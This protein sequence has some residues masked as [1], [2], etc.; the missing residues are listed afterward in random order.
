MADEGMDDETG[1]GGGG[2]ASSS[3]SAAA[4]AAA[5][6]AATAPRGRKPGKAPASASAASA[7]NLEGVNRPASRSPDKFAPHTKYHAFRDPKRDYLGR[8]KAADME[9]PE[10]ANVS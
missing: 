7:N 4:A 8:L 9:T 6:A 2:A 1:A 5:T 3:S 10:R